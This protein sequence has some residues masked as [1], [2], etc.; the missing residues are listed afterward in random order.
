MVNE[1]EEQAATVER[2]S[3]RTLLAATLLLALHFLLAVA[4]V[5]NK[6][7]TFDELAHLT[8]GYSNWFQDDYRLNV[9][10]G[11]VAQAIAAL[12]LLGMGLEF[13]G[14]DTPAWQA[15]DVWTIGQQF[16]FEL[17]NPYEA[18]LWRARAMIALVSVAFGALVFAWSRRWFGSRGGLLSLALYA[19]SPTMLAHARLVT[20]DVTATFLFVAS[21]GALWRLLHAVSWGNVLLAGL[22]M[23][24]LMLT[25]VSGGV[26]VPVALILTLLRL[27]SGRPLRVSL[28][29]STTLGSRAGQAGAFALVAALEVAI[30]VI[31]IWAAYG[32]RYSAF[33][34]L[35]SGGTGPGTLFYSVDPA[36]TG[37]LAGP[38]A[39]LRDNHLLPEAF[40]DGLIVQLGEAEERVAFM[41]GTYAMGGRWSFFPYCLAV[42]TPLPLFVLVALGLVATLRRGALG[43]R[44]Y[45]SAPLWVL[46]AVYWAFMLGGDM[47]IGARHVLVT[48]PVMFIVAGGAAGCAV[49]SRAL[50][51]TSAACLA[52]F[53]LE[54]ARVFPHYLA[55]FNQL[56][57][58]P[59]HGYEHLVDSSLDWGQDLPG[60]RDWLEERGLPDPR[61][62][63]Y[64]SYFG[65]ADPRYWR[66]GALALPSY[67]AWAAVRTQIAL[68]GGYYCISATHLQNM[69]THQWGRWTYRHEEAFRGLLPFARRCVAASNPAE[70]DAVLAEAGGEEQLQQILDTFQQLQFTRLV[71]YLRTR[72]PLAA[73]GHSILIFELTEDEVQAFLDGPPVE[74]HATSGIAGWGGE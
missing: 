72:P 7:N 23:G 52:L 31:L 32:F 6:S 33:E 53:A 14:R 65:T 37:V 62:P 26:I 49:R 34:P 46:L 43:A 17:G 5:R 55:Y 58:G 61:H 24:L 3:G 60:L 30:V 69:Y 66:L 9:E 47:N 39:W 10:S 59:E 36:R 67:G 71:A 21:A 54:S 16:F 38:I 27:A 1:H 73:I 44:L 29:G 15:S 57:G 63:V 13:P 12:P 25:K 68:H 11:L 64:L 74:V 4:S 42:K 35:A 50:L 41:N 40:L 22:C 51:G 28:R 45:R 8:S 20:T 19:L 18:M 2:L 70:L 56:A 48:L